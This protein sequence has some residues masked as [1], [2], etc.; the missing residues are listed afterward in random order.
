[1]RDENEV[2]LTGDGR[3]RQHTT[4]AKN[5]NIFVGFK[6]RMQLSSPVTKETFSYIFIQIEMRTK[7]R[8]RPR[9]TATV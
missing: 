1:M 4:L 8:V 5:L 6:R 9:L 3:M 2:W 7:K